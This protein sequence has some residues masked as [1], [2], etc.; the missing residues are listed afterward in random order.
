MF[1]LTF[2]GISV[3]RAT[4]VGYQKFGR[5][6]LPHRAPGHFGPK[7]FRPGT[8]QPKSFVFTRASRAGLHSLAIISTLALVSKSKGLSANTTI[9]RE[10]YTLKDCE[11]I[12][13]LKGMQGSTTI[14]QTARKYN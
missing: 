14:K 4:V 12:L 1:Q 5:A 9:K 13:K 11:G 8:P 6:A 3:L 10:G 2:N 7:P